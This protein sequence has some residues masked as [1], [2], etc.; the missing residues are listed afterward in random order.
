MIELI[1]RTVYN[2][3]AIKRLYPRSHVD[4]ILSDIEEIHQHYIFMIKGPDTLADAIREHNLVR[5]NYDSVDMITLSGSKRDIIF[6]VSKLSSSEHKGE[7]VLAQYF[8]SSFPD[9]FRTVPRSATGALKP[10]K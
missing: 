2:S 7:Q 10:W 6:L 1:G 4:S 3:D 5:C 9:I 8:L